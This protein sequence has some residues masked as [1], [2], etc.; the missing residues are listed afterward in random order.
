MVCETPF[1]RVVEYRP[2]CETHARSDEPREHMPGVMSL[3][4]GNGCTVYKECPYTVNT[5]D[6]ETLSM[7]DVTLKEGIEFHHLLC[8]QYH[9][10]TKSWHGHA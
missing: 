9:S 10:T 3:G 5:G 1:E 6:T 2:M 7:Y 8:N 4:P